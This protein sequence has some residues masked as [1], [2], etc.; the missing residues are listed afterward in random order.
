MGRSGSVK[1]GRARA[2][3]AAVM[4]SSWVASAIVRAQS[5][6]G[7][8]GGFG[9]SGGGSGGLGAASSVADAGASS[10]AGAEGGGGASASG[11]PSG[12]GGFPSSTVREEIVG[13]DGS[14]QTLVYVERMPSG[15]GGFSHATL[16]SVSERNE[17]TRVPLTTVTDVERLRTSRDPAIFREIDARIARAVA[18][19]RAR[20]GVGATLAA[21]E[22]EAR[23]PGVRCVNP[24]YATR[25]FAIGHLGAVQ[26]TPSADERASRLQFRRGNNGSTAIDVPSITLVEP[27]TGRA[28]LAPYDR[29][30]DARELPGTDRIAVLLRSDRCT[31]DGAHPVVAAALIDPP[32]DAPLPPLERAEWTEAQAMRLLAPRARRRTVDE[33]DGWY[34][35]DGTRVVYDNAWRVPNEPELLLVQFSRHDRSLS[36]T[37]AMGGHAPSHFALAR[38]RRGRWEIV[39]QFA[40]S[41]RGAY[42]G[43]A[44][45]A[46]SADLDGDGRPEVLVRAR[47]HDGSEYLTLLRVSPVDLHFV[48]SAEVA[49]DGRRGGASAC[50]AGNVT[51]RCRMGLDG[52]ALVLRC[53]HDTWSGTGADAHVTVSRVREERV[54]YNGGTASIETSER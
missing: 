44:Q 26:I 6:P 36:P 31:P 43:A 18:D 35:R 22:T 39:F 46:S 17:R 29:I 33:V 13:F 30:A 41:V 23:P 38:S 34:E 5:S 37:V 8:A 53:R 32:P 51:R 54:R 21:I 3:L 2:G 7:G 40:P 52:A 19:A 12:G 47:A 27:A 4:L 9:G 15:L 1:G 48:W 10:D 11:A 25:T 20:L 45:E 28:I 16:V 49:I 42:E 14:S 50:C 24:P